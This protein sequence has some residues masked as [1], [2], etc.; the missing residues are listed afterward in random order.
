MVPIAIDTEG[1][2]RVAGLAPRSSHRGDLI[3][4]SSV[5]DLISGGHALRVDNALVD[6]D[7]PKDTVALW[8]GEQFLEVAHNLDVPPPPLPAHKHELRGGHFFIGNPPEMFVYLE[9]W[10]ERSFERFA[11]LDDKKRRERIA[12]LM[13]WVLPSHIKTLSASWFAAPDP[14]SELERQL[15]AFGRGVAADVWKAK[16]EATLKS[17]QDTFSKIR[18]V[19]FTGSSGTCREDVAKSFYEEA[20]RLNSSVRY[21]TFKTPIETKARK[22]QNIP[23]ENIDKNILMT[24]G[25]EAVEQSPL[26]LALSLP[27]LKPELLKYPHLVV[28]DSVRH[29]SILEVLRWL[30]PAKLTMVGVSTPE[31]VRRARLTARGRDPET[32]ARHPTELEI[33][34]LSTQADRNINDDGHWTEDVRK[35][36]REL[37]AQ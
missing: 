26:F 27:E 15:K 16:L 31:E 5:D 37:V 34:L 9:R 1:S 35:L 33:P 29:R 13:R 23:F 32:L 21:A 4:L 19:A 22:N 7:I 20:L 10:I 25:Q 6:E 30:E 12:L 3:N 14:S 17:H 2:I 36:A 11:E 28:I 8:L 18:I 24:L